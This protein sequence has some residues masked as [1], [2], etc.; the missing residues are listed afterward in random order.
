MNIALRGLPASVA[1]SD[2]VVPVA[3]RDQ[4]FVRVFDRWNCLDLDI[5]CVWPFCRWTRNDVPH[6]SIISRVAGSEGLIESRGLSKLHAARKCERFVATP[7]FSAQPSRRSHKSRSSPSE[8]GDICEARHLRFLTVRFS[9]RHPSPY[10][11]L[12]EQVPCQY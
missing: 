9:K 5:R 12:I 11:Q 1:Q 10:E 2:V 7:R 8:T 3:A 4:C 6:F